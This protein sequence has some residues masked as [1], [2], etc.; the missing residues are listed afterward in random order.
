[1]KLLVFG[2]LLLASTTRAQTVE[3]PKYYPWEDTAIAEIPYR[4][5]GKGLVKRHRI[6]GASAFIG[7]MNGAGELQG[8]RTDLRGGYDVELPLNI[9][10]FVCEYGD[11]TRW[12]EELKLG[13]HVKR[14]AIHVRENRKDPMDAKLVCQ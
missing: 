10:W 2:C 9:R 3:C 11:N 7:E 12:W 13:P 5:N 4:H 14:C 8:R 1:M 6:T